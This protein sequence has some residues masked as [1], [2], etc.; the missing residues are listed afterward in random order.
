MHLSG[1]CV[2]MKREK[3]FC[4]IHA[5]NGPAWAARTLRWRDNCTEGA[6][7]LISHHI[8]CAYVFARGDDIRAYLSKNWFL[9][10]RQ[11]MRGMRNILLGGVR[12]RCTQHNT[13]ARAISHWGALSLYT[14]VKPRSQNIIKMGTERPRA[15]FVRYTLHYFSI[16]PISLSL[17]HI[18]LHNAMP[19]LSLERL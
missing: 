11:G 19:S 18:T 1:A 16:A 2:E 14:K 12:R 9:W 15:R 17:Q 8:I 13:M 4:A 3:W 10:R 5:F 6:K 7:H